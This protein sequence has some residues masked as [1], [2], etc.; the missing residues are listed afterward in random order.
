LNVVIDFIWP[1]AK[2]YTSL[3]KDLPQT[4]IKKMNQAK[5]KQPSKTLTI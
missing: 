5:E 2:T 1:F 3:Y 4:T